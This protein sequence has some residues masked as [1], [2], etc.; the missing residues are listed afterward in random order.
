[1]NQVEMGS[2]ARSLCWL[3]RVFVVVGCYQDGVL[4]PKH[5]W[6]HDQ[7]ELRKSCNWYVL[8]YS[9]LVWYL[10]WE[11]QCFLEIPKSFCPQSVCLTCIAVCRLIRP[12][13]ASDYTMVFPHSPHASLLA[14][15]G[16][17]DSQQTEAVDSI[18]KFLGSHT[19]VFTITTMCTCMCIH[20]CVVCFRISCV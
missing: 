18:Q 6:Q 19:G 7:F 14:T 16:Q 3:C 20:V 4:S 9:A 17:T 5:T 11:S 13:N 10:P 8:V 15:V 12:S 2:I 1:M